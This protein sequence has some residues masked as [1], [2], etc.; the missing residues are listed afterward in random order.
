V[1]A[2]SRRAFLGGALTLAAGPTAL[3]AQPAG[4]MPLIGFVT[5]RPLPPPYLES[6][7]CA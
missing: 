2:V 4:T 7:S 1:T 5:E 3:R 6:W